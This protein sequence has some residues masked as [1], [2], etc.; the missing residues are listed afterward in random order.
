MGV[1]P[2][3][4]LVPLA[5]ATVTATFALAALVWPDRATAAWSTVRARSWSGIAVLASLFVYVVTLGVW[6]QLF[7]LPG[8]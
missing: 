5:V 8:V 1:G 4:D 7:E 6:S 3:V 2:V